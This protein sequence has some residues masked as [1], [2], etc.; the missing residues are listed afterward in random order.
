M[1]F[2]TSIIR[3]PSM[4][5]PMKLNNIHR[6]GEILGNFCVVI[7]GAVALLVM[8]CVTTA[9]PVRFEDRSFADKIGLQHCRVS[10]PLSP[11]E[12]VELGRKLQI[13]PNPEKDPEWIRMVS[14]QQPGDE[15]RLTSCGE[16]NP[17]FYALIRNGAVI[18][19]YLLPVLD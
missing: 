4:M 7:V 17:Y 13:Y 2:S 12:A 15:L 10:I 14:T 6:L 19:R 9:G 3:H 16:G 11:S 1:G 5:H 8:G 18:Y